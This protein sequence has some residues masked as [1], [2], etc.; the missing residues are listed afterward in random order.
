MNTTDIIGTIGVSL[1][2][3]AYFLNIFSLI[4]KDGNLFYI[5]NIF[6]GA[7]ACFSSYLIRFWPFVILEGTWAVIS[8]V[9]LLKSIKKPQD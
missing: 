4:K 7:I 3:I 6:G 5:L 2:L 8:V 1:I 9:A